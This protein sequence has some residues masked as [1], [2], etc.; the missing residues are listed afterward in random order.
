M[1]LL[2]CLTATTESR[3]ATATMSAHD[4]TCGHIL[5]SRALNDAVNH[6]KSTQGIVVRNSSLLPRLGCH[7]AARSHRSPAKI[8]MLMNPENVKTYVQIWGHIH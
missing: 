2:F 1:F 5:S 4:T 8:A 3:A 6:V 7:Q